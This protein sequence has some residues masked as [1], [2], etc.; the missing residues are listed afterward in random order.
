[1]TNITLT[2]TDLDLARITINAVLLL[3]LGLAIVFAKR[4]EKFGSRLLK[5]RLPFRVQQADTSGFSLFSLR[6]NS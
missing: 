2:A 1:M 3:G 6:G 4:F 5:M